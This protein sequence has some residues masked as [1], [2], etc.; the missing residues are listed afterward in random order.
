MLKKDESKKGQAKEILQSTAPQVWIEEFEMLDMQI[1]RFIG[2][3]KFVN[4]I[5]NYMKEK[6]QH[7]TSRYGF[8]QNCG[9]ENRN[10][11]PT[12][13][14]LNRYIEALG[15]TILVLRDESMNL[16]RIQPEDLQ[17]SD[18]QVELEY[19]EAF[20]LELENNESL[21]ERLGILEIEGF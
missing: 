2:H 13:E 10:N 17:A 14:P 4:L 5:T 7:N 15:E 18:I 8:C 11:E 6:C 16:E 21:R 1:K 20:M 3:K 9:V 12:D 19:S